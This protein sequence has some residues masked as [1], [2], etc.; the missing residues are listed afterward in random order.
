MLD[1]MVKRERVFI[2][3]YALGY[4]WV[5][6]PS[7]GFSFEC[8]KEGNPLV[9]KM[10]DPALENLRKCRDGTYDVVFMGIRDYSRYYT[11]DAHG[12][13][14]CGREVYLHNDYGHGIDCECGRI[15]NSSGQELAPRSQWED[16]YD[17]DSVAPYCVE[18]G[19]N[20]GD[21]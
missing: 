15:Y 2:E 17:E 13:C 10:G 6:D 9:E 14:D 21:Y 4:E 18:F 20:L 16:R 5:D 12:T 8:D 7:S 3:D 19:Y 1:N 11:E